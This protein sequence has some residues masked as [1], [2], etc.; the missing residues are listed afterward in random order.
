MMDIYNSL[1]VDEAG[2]ESGGEMREEMNEADLLSNPFRITHED[3][4]TIR[5]ADAIMAFANRGRQHD[6]QLEYARIFWFDTGDLPSTQDERAIR[7]E[8][9]LHKVRFVVC[10]TFSSLM[11]S[12]STSRCSKFSGRIV[13]QVRPG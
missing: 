4:R 11:N 12:S 8:L 5:R 1:T 10:T 7:A 13:A 9:R 6:L 3:I 2:G